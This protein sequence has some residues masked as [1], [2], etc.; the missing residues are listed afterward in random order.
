M[1]PFTRTTANW[2]PVGLASQLPSIEDDMRIVPRCKAFNVPTN[3]PMERVEDIDLPGELKDQVLV[4]KYKGKYHAIDHQCPHSS[5][6]LSQGNVFDIEDFGITLSAGI[7]CPKHGWSFDLFTGQADRGNYKL[8]VWEVQL[9]DTPTPGSIDQEVWVRRKQRI[10]EA[11]NQDDSSHYDFVIVGGGT[12]GLVIA[13]RLS[14]L[15]DVTVA[16]IEAGDSVLNNHN[17]S[18]VTGYGRAFGTEIDWAYQTEDQTYAGGGKQTMRAGKAIGGTSTINGM[19]YTRA[20]KAQID[21]WEHVG[22]K[23]WNWDSLFPYYKK[24]TRLQVPTSDQIDQGADYYIDYHGKDGPV[25]IG[26]PRAMT[27]STMLPQLDETFQRLGLPFNRDANGGSMVGLTVHPNTVDR[28]ANVRHDAARAYYWPYENRSN[29]KII[30][31]TYANKVIWASN[32]GS[33]AVAIGVE[34]TG[35]DGIGTIYAS[36]EVI[37]SAGSLKSSVL[38]ELSGIGNPDV[39]SKYDIPVRVNISTVGENLQDQTNSG[40]S[41]EG[42]ALWLGSPTF[43]A[44]PSA[45]QIFGDNVSDVASLVNASL[46]DYARAVS[47]YSNGAVQEVNALNAFQLQYDLIFKSQVPYAEIVLLPIGHSFSSEYWPLLPFSRGSIHIQSADSS[48]PPSINPNYFM[49]DQDLSANAEVA[50][51]VRKAFHTA[52]LSNLVG[53]ELAPGQERVPENASE[54]IW[55]S[56]VKS[57][58]RSNFHPVGTASMLPR[59]K[60]G[61]VG[62]DLR[63]YGTKN[64]RVVDASI[65]PFQLCGHLT[66]TLYAVAERA[67]DLIK[68]RY[69]F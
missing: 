36:K 42:N 65:L 13:N 4:F 19:S 50:R 63:V 47:K 16:V 43:S 58:Y 34:V 3:G 39:L 29:L 52:P 24:S 40:L 28:E 2:H 69:I 49:F 56:W 37:L 64:V 44:L 33:E 5:F 11:K 8:K 26:W 48:Q 32:A 27:N 18:T 60:G 23:G 14:E 41:Y 38:L 61:V 12:S 1:N 31:N 66:S 10:A 51:Y 45:S 35:V 6:P 9:R 54:P 55:E 21:A 57:N 17:V 7:T 68:R 62:N 22:N 20:Q 25:K 67:S 46:A 53:E 30:S 15:R 59:D